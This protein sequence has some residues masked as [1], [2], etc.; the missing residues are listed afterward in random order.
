MCKKKKPG[1]REFFD[2][3]DKSRDKSCGQLSLL[4]LFVLDMSYFHLN[5]M[6][7]LVPSAEWKLLAGVCS[8]KHLQVKDTKS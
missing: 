2:L 6:L 7:E 4:N 3:E 1:I 5:Q 8:Q